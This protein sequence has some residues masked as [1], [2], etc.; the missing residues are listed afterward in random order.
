MYYHVNIYIFIT[1][2]LRKSILYIYIIILNLF[3]Y[4]TK[5]KISRHVAK[6]R[7]RIGTKKLISLIGNVWSYRSTFICMLLTHTTHTG[8]LRTVTESH[9]AWCLNPN[10]KSRNQL[11]ILERH[12]R[13]WKYS[14]V[15]LKLYFF[16]DFLIFFFLAEKF[17]SD[18]KQVRPQR[19]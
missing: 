5:D 11:P 7:Y 18:Y 13:Y 9:I 10:Q 14:E 19:K 8:T 6:E 15:P 16:L 1:V 17:L 3:L 4:N 12:S 2:T